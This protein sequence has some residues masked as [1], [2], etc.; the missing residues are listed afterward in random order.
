VAVTPK[1]LSQSLPLIEVARDGR[2]VVVAMGDTGVP[3]RLLASRFG[4]QW[5]YAGAGVAPG[6]LPAERMVGEFR[7]RDVGP[8]TALYGVVGNNVMHSISPA[9]H[10]AAFAAS[11]IDAVYV[12]L[13][14]TAFDDFLSFADALGFVG[15]SVTVPFKLDAIRAADSSDAR[16]RQIGA[17]NTL[18]RRNGVW[19]ATNTDVEGLLA[20][21]EAAYPGPLRGV[22]TAVLGAGGAARAAVVALKA[23]GAQVTV[24]ARR[25]QQA[26][27][28][29]RALDAT[30][31]PWPPPAG[32]WDLL[33]NCTPLG[34]PSARDQSPL[35]DDPFLGRLV[36]DLSY[37]ADEPR[38]LQQA[39]QAGCRV[40]DGLPMLIAQAE[41]QFECWTGVP[42]PPGVMRAAAE[43]RIGGHK[44]RLETSA[45]P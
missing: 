44:S 39:R 40:L 23:R 27:E 24:Y 30:A 5:T 32:S 3:S 1:R 10:N 33:I 17:A 16:T 13:L 37:G 6:Q 28:V 14:T 7:F 25:H 38:L 22:R 31:T 34:G 42:P 43:R 11:S 21:L 4:S 26:L 9:M 36:Y 2:A 29:A 19:E 20:P 18:R 35:P 41:R 8:A 45:A 15:A 12:P